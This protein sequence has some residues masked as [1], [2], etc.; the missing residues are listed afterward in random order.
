[1][2]RTWWEKVGVLEGVGQLNAG[3][4]KESNVTYRIDIERHMRERLG[5][6]MPTEVV[7]GSCRTVASLLSADDM[8]AIPPSQV[9]DL[10]LEDGR[11]VGVM[12]KR[13]PIREFPA[14]MIVM[15]APPDFFAAY[16]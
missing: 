8:R 13:F 14:E 9:F 16:V 7:G 1:M 2:S 15:N 5:I 4:P 6:G 10:L 3:G 12:V 11:T